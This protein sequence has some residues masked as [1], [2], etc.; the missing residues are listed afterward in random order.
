MKATGTLRNGVLMAAREHKFNPII[1]LI[2]SQ[3]W[4]GVPR[5]EHWLTDV[6]E[7]PDRPYTRLIGKCFIMGLV[8]RA[9]QPGCKFDYMVIF[10]GGQGVGKSTLTRVLGGDNLRF[11]PLGPIARHSGGVFIRRKIGDKLGGVGPELWLT[12]VFTSDPD[13]A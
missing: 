10:E 13:L 8:K 1:D 4:D 7:V 5:L 3:P 6:Y 2:K 11:F 9:L 12:I